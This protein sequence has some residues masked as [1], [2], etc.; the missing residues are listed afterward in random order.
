MSRS[1][2][3]VRILSLALCLSLALALFGVPAARAEDK[4]TTEANIWALG[5]PFYASDTVP[6]WLTP[7]CGIHQVH[8]YELNDDGSPDFAHEEYPTSLSVEWLSGDF[9]QEL[10]HSCMY[11]VGNNLVVDSKP[12]TTPGKA[13]CRLIADGNKYHV[14][15]EFDLEVIDYKD[16]PI[17]VIGQKLEVDVKVGEEVDCYN[18]LGQFETPLVFSY[19]EFI[20]YVNGVDFEF[21]SAT[22]QEE[23]TYD[24]RIRLEAGN[25]SYCV[26]VTVHA[27]LTGERKA[28]DPGT[29]EPVTVKNYAELMKAVTEKRSNRILISA[30][31][32]HGKL[33]DSWE[34]K[35]PEGRTVVFAPEEGQESAVIDGSVGITGKGRAVFDR[36]SITGSEN[37]PA[38]FVESGTEVTAG[39]IRGAD[40]KK[41]N[42]GTAL[43]VHNATVRAGRVTGGNSV[44]HLGGDGVYAFGSA[45]VEVVSAAGG[46]SEQGVGGSGVVAIYRTTEV[47]VTEEA[48][49]G[50][51]GTAPGKPVLSALESTVKAQ[52]ARDGEQTESKKTWNPDA[53]TSS[54]ILEYALR[55]GKTDIV[56]DK[57]FAW[58]G[59]NS[60]LFYI[61][62]EETIRISAPEGVKKLTVKNGGFAFLYGTWEISGID[63]QNTKQVLPLYVGGKAQVTWNGS[64]KNSNSNTVQMHDDALLR[65]NG[66]IDGTHKSYYTVGVR[67]RSRLEITG[68]ISATTP[69]ALNIQE[70]GS[71]IMN[72]NVKISGQNYPAVYANGGSLWL[73]GNITGRACLLDASGASV[74]VEGTIS[75]SD[76]KHYAAY[77]QE[78]DVLING[79]IKAP[80][81]YYATYYGHLLYNGRNCHEKEQDN[82]N[83]R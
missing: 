39:D 74:R 53:I 76:K 61:P 57:K 6:Q 73:T 72:G 56:L 43:E 24:I 80:Y 26:P 50:N 23:G 83:S 79:Q 66:N 49:G 82:W 40:S 44:A 58:I 2:R 46:H 77:V 21:Q 65:M 11:P 52:A 47:T 36:V 48:V 31:Y 13:R 27:S 9:S 78:G 59:D 33:P 22:F 41:G 7:M 20:P 8:L 15:Q 34:I 69:N 10:V 42:G 5:L 62:S 25:C 51:G 17:E 70:N 37:H 45:K 75:G 55:C 4:K 30:K 14:E 18:I 35:I 3:F 32:K 81:P 63:I 71:V 60:Y 64:V 67:G 1:S 28:E 38:L 16:K 19:T 12:L 29:D 54:A 68:N